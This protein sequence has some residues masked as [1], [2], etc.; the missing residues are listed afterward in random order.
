MEVIVTLDRGFEKELSVTVPWD[1]IG[2]EYERIV[3]R[4]AKLPLRGF[5]PGKTPV[6]FV[7]SSFAQ[8][9]KNDLLTAVSAR[10]CRKALQ[11]SGMV[12]GTPVEISDSLLQKKE[13][14]KFRAAFIVMPEFDLPNYACLG[15]SSEYGEARLDEISRKL[16][17]CTD[18]SLHPCYIENELKYSENENGAEADRNDAEK[19]VKLM[20]ILKSIAR[21]DRIEIDEKDMEDRIG[22]VAEENGVTP[23]ELRKFLAENNGLARF[24]DT[25]LAEAVL[26]YIAEIQH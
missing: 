17:E 7:E 16:L 8:Q 24:A 3:K 22:S 6:G 11:D 2:A 10:L 23:E 18:I 15:L 5:R 9:I 13:Y 21:Q 1:M 26:E 25:L 14:L 19:R 4:Y 20:L 12:A